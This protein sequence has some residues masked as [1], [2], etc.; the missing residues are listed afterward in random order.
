[1]KSV[2]PAFTNSIVLQASGGLLKQIAGVNFAWHET[3]VTLPPGS[4]SA[5]LKERLLQAV[6]E[7]VGSYQQEIVRQAEQVM[8]TSDS[9]SVVDAVPQVQ[10]QLGAAGIEALVR[11]PVQLHNAVEIDARVFEA[12]LRVVSPET[13]CSA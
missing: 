9:D 8:R 6:N 10:L 4:D 5:E 12:L 1:M 13:R 7:V 11:Y 2:F 3:K